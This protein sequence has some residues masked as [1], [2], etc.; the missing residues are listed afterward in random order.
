MCQNLVPGMEGVRLIYIDIYVAALDDTFEF[1]C[2]ENAAADLICKDVYE[3]LTGKSGSGFWLCDVKRQRILSGEKSLREQMII[4]GS[5][6]M[7][8]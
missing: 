3:A 6:L 5:R 1:K 7:L 8:L 4:H 2:D